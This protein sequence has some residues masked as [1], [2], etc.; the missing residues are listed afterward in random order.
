MTEKVEKERE[1]KWLQKVKRSFSLSSKGEE[2][3]EEKT[4]PHIGD[5][6]VSSGLRLDLIVAVV[7]AIIYLKKNKWKSLKCKWSNAS[8]DTK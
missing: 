2:E 7:V 1:E 8:N 3:E 4:A 5:F 6:S